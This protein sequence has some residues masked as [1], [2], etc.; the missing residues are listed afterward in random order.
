MLKRLR[1]VD[2]QIARFVAAEKRRQSKVLEMIPSENYVSS[3]VAQVLGSALGNKYSEGYPGKRYYQGNRV[4]DEVE[5]LAVER[6]KKLFG[7]P[8]ANVQP[9]SGTQSLEAVENQGRSPSRLPRR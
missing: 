3:A 6:F 4:V 9:Y 7:V 8:H 2:P 5:T 1:D